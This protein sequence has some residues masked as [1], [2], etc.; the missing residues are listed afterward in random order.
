MGAHTTAWTVHVDR[1]RQLIIGSTPAAARKRVAKDLATERKDMVKDLDPAFSF[2]ADHFSPEGTAEANHFDDVASLQNA[3]VRH[4]EQVNMIPGATLPAADIAGKYESGHRRVLLEHLGLQHFATAQ[5]DHSPDELRSAIVG[6]L[7]VGSVQQDGA[8]SPF[9]E[10]EVDTNRKPVHR[11]VLHHLKT[12]EATYPGALAAARL[13]DVKDLRSPAVALVTK[14]ATTED[15]PKKKRTKTAK[16]AA[17]VKAPSSVGTGFVPISVPWDVSAFGVQ[18]T[19]VCDPLA[20][21]P[22]LSYLGGRRHG[23]NKPLTRVGKPW[24]DADGD[25]LTDRLAEMVAAYRKDLRMPS[26]YLG[27]VE[28]GAVAQEYNLAVDVYRDTAPGGYQRIENVGGGDCLIHALSDVR[29]GIDLQNAGTALNQI[30]DRLGPAGPRSVSGADIAAVRSKVDGRIEV[31]AVEHAVLDIVHNEIEGRGTQGLGPNMKALLFNPGLQ[32]DIGNVSVLRR[33]AEA[34]KAV[35]AKEAQAKAN[36]EK[37]RML[38]AE[39]VAALKAAALLAGGT[40]PLGTPSSAVP[41]GTGPEII[42]SDETLPDAGKPTDLAD[43]KGDVADEGVDMVVES[44]SDKAGGDAG[45][46]RPVQAQERYPSD[47][48]PH[49][50]FALLHTGGNHYVAL[51]RTT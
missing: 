51:V 15:G 28:G 33:R 46:P 12:I 45:P 27:Q 39:K 9:D 48:A 38:R 49:P 41:I 14:L 21:L 31:E 17:K 32:V 34:E 50:D 42:M 37:A 24:L 29:R 11:L 6:L 26:T 18:T 35:E 44:M 16:E 40:A 8:A 10:I 25:L 20:L 30:V 43:F 47:G 7:D 1:V 23:G 4:L 5:R 22:T 2:P 36:A 19:E 3:I 13:G